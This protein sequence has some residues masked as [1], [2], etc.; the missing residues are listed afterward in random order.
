MVMGYF[1]DNMV[2][3]YLCIMIIVVILMEVDLYMILKWIIL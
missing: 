2:N 3:I 1:L